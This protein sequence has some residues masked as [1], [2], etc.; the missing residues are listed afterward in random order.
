MLAYKIEK[1]LRECWK[2]LD[3]TVEKGI[4]KLKSV[5]GIKA[6]FSPTKQVIWIPEPDALS[7]QLLDKA[8]VVL[9]TKETTVS[10][11]EKLTK[12]RKWHII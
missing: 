12:H 1:Y 6:R 8:K 10:T 11:K 2:E 4:E 3:I 7:R 5:A 9:P